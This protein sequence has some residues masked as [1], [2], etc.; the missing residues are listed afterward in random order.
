MTLHVEDGEF[1]VVGASGC[2]KTTIGVD[3]LSFGG[4]KNGVFVRLRPAVIKATIGRFL[5]YV[6]DRERGVA[7]MMTTWDT[8]R[9]FIDRFVDAVLAVPP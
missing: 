3:L 6:F 8:T 4:T 2:G 9:E 1:L 5:Y 7:R